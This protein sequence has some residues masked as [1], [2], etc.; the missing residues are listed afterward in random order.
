MNRQEP[1]IVNNTDEE[2]IDSALSF[3]NILEDRG[4][5]DTI[6]MDATIRENSVIN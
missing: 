6:A 5:N 1:V 3:I 2:K 4:N